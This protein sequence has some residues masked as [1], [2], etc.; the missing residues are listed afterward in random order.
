MHYCTENIAGLVQDCSNSSALA[1]ELLQSCTKPVLCT[2]DLAGGGGGGGGGSC[3]Y[4]SHFQAFCTF[5]ENWSSDWAKFGRWSHYVTPQ[6]SSAEFQSFPGLSLVSP[7]PCICR[8]TANQI[9]IK[10]GRWT[11]YIMGLL[12]PCQLLVTL[13]WIPTI[14][15]LLIISAFSVHLQTNC[16]SHLPKS[17]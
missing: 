13:Y 5:A 4:L 7:F 9:D 16:W 6:A 15:L 10:F 1:M 14:P 3:I 12:R 8:Q 2:H 17:W 11:H